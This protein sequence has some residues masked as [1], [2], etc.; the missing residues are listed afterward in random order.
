MSDDSRN[1]KSFL[2]GWL[3][4][5]IVYVIGILMLVIIF[6][7]YYFFVW[8]LVLKIIIFEGGEIILE[9]ISF[10]WSVCRG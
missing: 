5:V 9:F 4:I 10:V 1:C 6:G 8:Y 2:Y 7:V 3:V